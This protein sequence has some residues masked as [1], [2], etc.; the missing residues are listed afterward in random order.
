MHAPRQVYSFPV[1]KPA[2]IISILKELNIEMSDDEL[3][4]PEKNKEHTRHILESL[5][6]MCTGI[7]REEMAQPAF[8]GL[9][10]LNYPELHEESIPQLNSFRAITKMMEIC[11]IQDFSMKDLMAP[12]SKRLKRQLSGTFSCVSLLHTIFSVSSSYPTQS[13]TYAIINHIVFFF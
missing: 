13:M 12:S 3:Q 2:E 8:S 9:S 5:A 11:G 1:M 10:V 7:T 4:N 6:A